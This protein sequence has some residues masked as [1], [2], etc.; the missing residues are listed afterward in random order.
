MLPFAISI[1]VLGLTQ[2]ALVAVPRP[3]A[4][5]AL[6]RLRGRAWAAIPAL[7]VIGVVFAVRA[8]SQTAQGLTYL[9]LLAV[10][11]L[12]AL[13][14]GHVA[15]G[16]R[17]AYALAVVPLF[18][19]A[20]W[21]RGSLSGEAAGLAL[22]ALSCV[23]LGALL[24]AVAPARWLKAGIL[25]MAAVDTVLVVINLLQPSSNA[26]NAA[27][28][29][30][31][32]PQLQRALF[33]TAVMG[34]GDLFV[35]ATLGALLAADTPL[36]RRASVLA[37]ALALLFDLLFFAVRELPATVPIALTLIMCELATRRPVRAAGALATSAV[38]LRGPPG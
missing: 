18:A 16:A 36:Q 2:G 1:G 28:P 8:A 37:V 26:L 3:D 5:P 32:L 30:A 33:G 19:L 13:A 9:A 12:A 17:H 38:T 31:G 24:T 10:P 25:V 7:S 35:A 11:P 4:F 14:L 22:T 34:Y 23:T 21:Q 15:R 20:W 6:A 29:A 27:H